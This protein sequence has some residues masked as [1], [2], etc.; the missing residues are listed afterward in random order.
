MRDLKILKGPGYIYDL[1][2][3]GFLQFNKEYCLEHMINHD[4]RDE[5][6]AFFNAILK[7]FPAI[8]QDLF[9]FFHVLDSGRSFMS[10]NYFSPYKHLFASGYD[11]KALYKEVADLSTLTK[12]VIAT[13]L[14]NL[15]QDEVDDCAQNL[16]ALFE[17]IK[18]SH[19]SD[20]VKCRLYEFFIAPRPYQQKLRLT[21][22]VLERALDAYYQQHYLDALDAFGRMTFDSLIQS[23]S[24]F[25]DFLCTLHKSTSCFL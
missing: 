25:K 22:A 14:Y 3:I 20:Q 24:K 16:T 10:T 8:P 12:R 9:L 5:D 23:F 4:K 7:E 1:F 15:S 2:F 6:E 21:L 17:R 13:Y 18:N 11:Y 19:Y